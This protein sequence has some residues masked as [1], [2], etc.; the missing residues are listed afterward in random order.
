MKAARSIASRSASGPRSQCATRS[1]T[2]EVFHDAVSFHALRTETVRAPSK[3]SLTL[4]RVFI[5]AL[6]RNNAVEEGEDKRR[7]AKGA[8]RRRGLICPL[9][10]SNRV[11][12]KQSPSLRFSAPFA[13]LRLLDSFS[14]TWI[15]LSLNG[16]WA[17]SITSRSASG[18]CSQRA[19]TSEASET[20]HDIVSFHALRTETV[21]APY[22]K[23][24]PT[25]H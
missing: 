19:S 22:M 25:R 13:S 24:L 15:R 6:S 23:S 11:C 14:T 4:K 2:S 12:K 18:P 17:G 21:R 16:E 3:S 20:F 1:K 5:Q 7:D 8:E 10:S 9:S